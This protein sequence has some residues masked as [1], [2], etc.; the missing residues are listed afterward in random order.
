MEHLLSVVPPT[1]ALKVAPLP[2]SLRAI[3]WLVWN[4][5][6]SVVR[7]I[8]RLKIRHLSIHFASH[9]LREY[10]RLMAALR[11]LLVVV[12]CLAAE[13]AP[14][15][16]VAPTALTCTTTPEQAFRPLAATRTPRPAGRLFPLSF[17]IS[18]RG[19]RTTLVGC[20]FS[21]HICD[22]HNMLRTKN[23]QRQCQRGA[24]IPN[25]A[26]R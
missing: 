11:Q 8:H 2:A 24:H 9:R 17:L 25:S 19:G 16:V 13:T 1:T 10:N 3:A 21:Y 22:S 20:K 18:Q 4:T 12:L 23:I 26:P 6:T 5:L 14:S 15:S 7:T